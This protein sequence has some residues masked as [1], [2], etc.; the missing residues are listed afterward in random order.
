MQSEVTLLERIFIILSYSDPL[1]V[2]NPLQKH[3]VFQ[4]RDL[5]KIKQFCSVMLILSVFQFSKIIQK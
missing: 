5:I 2:S 1:S 3:F 4:G